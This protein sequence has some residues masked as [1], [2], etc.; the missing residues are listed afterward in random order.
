MNLDNL[1]IEPDNSYHQPSTDP[2]SGIKAIVVVMTVLF[3]VFTSVLAIFFYD[4]KQKEG[5]VIN[6]SNAGNTNLLQNL[7]FYH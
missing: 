4:K 3:M 2:T 5:D 7:L 6:A 1:H